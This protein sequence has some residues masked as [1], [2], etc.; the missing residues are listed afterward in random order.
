MRPPKTQRWVWLAQS[1]FAVLLIS[2]LAVAA[3]VEPLAPRTTVPDVPVSRGEEKP[4][5]IRSRASDRALLI[6]ALTVRFRE[7]LATLC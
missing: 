5:S 3:A 4:V 2:V 6:V 7:R 1:P